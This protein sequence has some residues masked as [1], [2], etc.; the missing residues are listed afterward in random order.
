MTRIRLYLLA[1]CAALAACEEPDRRVVSTD[2]TVQLVRNAAR[3]LAGVATDHDA[4]MNA[5]GESRY[6]LLGEATHGTHEFYTE[7]ARISRRLIEER[8]FAAIVVEGE[9]PAGRRVNEYLHGRGSDASPEA[10]LSGF[11]EFPVWMWRNAEVRDFVRDLRAL[12][13]GRAA[14][15]RVSFYGM[16][17]YSLYPSQRDVIAYLERID[18]AAAAR[19]RTRYAC[20]APYGSDPQRYGREASTSAST[21]CAAQAAEQLTEMEQRFAAAPADPELFDA[22]QS[23]R[24]VR[25]AEEFYRRSF[26]RGEAAWNARDRHMAATLAALATHLEARGQRGRIAVWAHNS[27]VGD[28]RATEFGGRGQL[29]LG[30]LMRERALAETFLLGFTT[31]EGTV[32]AATSWGTPGR[33]TALRPALAG[34]YSALFHDTGIQSFLLILRGSPVAAPFRDMRLERAVG[35]VYAPQTERQSHYFLAALADQFDAVIHLDRT[36][37]VN[38]LP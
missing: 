38:P 24:V 22:V 7:R 14:G 3:P 11:T 23:A 27:H 1:T 18:P 2:E 28:A 36:T 33:A 10:A 30:Q 37:A 5:I 8:G 4:L 35:V 17:V 20:F 15:N 31:Y 13:A 6:V 12:N 21:S 16:D 9:F 25:G 26:E 32:V 34:S 19:A 29:T